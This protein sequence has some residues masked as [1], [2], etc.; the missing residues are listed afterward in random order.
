MCSLNQGLLW[1][2]GIHHQQ[3]V[4][5]KTCP[6]N[7]VLDISTVYS[8]YDDISPSGKN[9]K[10]SAGGTTVKRD[11]KVNQENYCLTKITYAARQAI[12]IAPLFHCQL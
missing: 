8:Y 4:A 11:N 10:K 3:E 12:T 9:V 1:N 2:T 6:R 7:S 5:T